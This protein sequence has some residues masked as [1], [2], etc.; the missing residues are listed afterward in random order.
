MSCH[1]NSK[2][3]CKVKYCL[4][5]R[6]R[7][8]S[9]PHFFILQEKGEMGSFNF[10][11]NA[12]R[13]RSPC[14]LKDIQGSSLDSG[15]WSHTSSIMFWSRLWG[16]QPMLFRWYY[17]VAQNLIALFVYHNSINFD[18]ITS[19]TGDQ[20][21]DHPLYFAGFVSD[22]FCRSRGKRKYVGLQAWCNLSSEVYYLGVWFWWW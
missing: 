5:Q 18:K 22:F 20:H 7:F 3:M 10:F 6:F 21:T 12:I 9:I 11:K 15:R 8:W 1:I 13:N 14:F 2:Q 19:T 17:L 4:D 16:G